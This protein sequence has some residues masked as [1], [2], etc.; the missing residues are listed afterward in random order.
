MNI[1]YHVTN[2]SVNKNNQVAYNLYKKNGFTEYQDTGKMIFMSTNSNYKE[3][4]SLI[5]SETPDIPYLEYDTEG[6]SRY[7]SFWY[8]DKLQVLH[9]YRSK[10]LRYILHL[11]SNLRLLIFLIWNMILKEEPLLVI[12]LNPTITYWRFC[13]LSLKRSL[14]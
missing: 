14:I 8:S 3:Q 11:L 5:E 4:A 9:Y 12:I 2:L 10:L 13:Q 6:Q 1:E 7:L